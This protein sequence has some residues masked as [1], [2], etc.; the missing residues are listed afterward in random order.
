MVD[1][2]TGCPEEASL[3]PGSSNGGRYDPRPSPQSSR[4]QM[5]CLMARFGRPIAPK[6]GLDAG[7]A[8]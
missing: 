1:G 8:L 7:S 3:S 4:K 2:A 5:H 6:P